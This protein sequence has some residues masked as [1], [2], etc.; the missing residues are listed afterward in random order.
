MDQI[1][2]RKIR[3]AEWA[4]VYAYDGKGTRF[5]TYACDAIPNLT[6]TH[7]KIGKRRSR[8]VYTVIRT[9]EVNLRTDSILHA[10]RSYNAEAKKRAGVSRP[11]AGSPEQARQPRRDTGI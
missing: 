7:E 5:K 10:I 4:Q 3:D 9:G 11:A 2:Q 1:T 8:S 6:I